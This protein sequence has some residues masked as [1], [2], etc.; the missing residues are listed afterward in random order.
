MI[1]WCLDIR[2]CCQILCNL[3]SAVVQEKRD[4]PPKNFSHLLPRVVTI[5]VHRGWGGCAWREG[6]GRRCGRAKHC[7]ALGRSPLP[8][9]TKVEGGFNLVSTTVLLQETQDGVVA[10]LARIPIPPP[11]LLL[12]AAPLLHPFPS[13]RMNMEGDC[14][15]LQN[16]DAIEVRGL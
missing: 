2:Q 11:D 1:F 12:P 6:G 5:E 13:L 3:G 16:V 9:A 14:N 8:L 7:P 10:T 15:A 4:N